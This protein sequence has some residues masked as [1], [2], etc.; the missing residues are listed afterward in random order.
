MTKLS[1][2]DIKLLWYYP[3]FTEMVIFEKGLE[4]IPESPSAGRSGS[5]RRGASTPCSG[6][7]AALAGPAR[8]ALSD[9]DPG[10]TGPS[11]R[12]K[13]VQ[14]FLY[15]FCARNSPKQIFCNPSM[16]FSW[17]LQIC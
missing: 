11:P 9:P 4:C 6:A 3:K 8:P 16:A 7:C 13:D 5:A 1:H 12:P 14:W 17:L 15:K 2:N 10:R